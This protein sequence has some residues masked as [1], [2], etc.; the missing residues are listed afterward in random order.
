MPSPKPKLLIDYESEGFPSASGVINGTSVL[1]TSWDELIWAA[2]TVGRPNR[3]Y[4]FR[5]GQASIYEALFRLSLTRMALEQRPGGRR[6]RRTAAAK[7][8]DPS[9]KGAVSYF[10]GMTLCK[11]FSARL[12]YAPWLLHLDVFRPDLDI[13]LSGRSRPDLVGKTNSNEGVALESKGRLSKPDADAKTKAKNQA[14]RVVSIDGVS[15]TYK[16]G[17]IAYFR[18][19]VLRFYWRDPEARNTSK[20]IEVKIRGED[21]SYYYRPIFELFQSR[22]Q[23]SP[24]REERTSASIEE[25]DIDLGIHPVILRLLTESNWAGAREASV[26]LAQE[27]HERGYQLDGIRIDA[28]PSWRL[29]FSEFRE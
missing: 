2:V 5:H 8:L 4:V 28:G 1:E 27:F 29:P 14:T 16:I 20:T 18:N 22:Y 9:E 26:K 3:Q 21:W 17:G 7:T 6:L 19:E 12:L 13:Q 11:L 10:L 24:S 25:V 23:T 15:P